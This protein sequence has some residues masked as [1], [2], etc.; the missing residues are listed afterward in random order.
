MG[1]S[2]DRNIG[3][4][5]QKLRSGLDDDPH[6]K[7]M[8]SL[9]TFCFIHNVV[10]TTT[11]DDLALEEEDMVLADLKTQRKKLNVKKH[12]VLTEMKTELL[13]LLQLAESELESQIV[14]DL[15]GLR[16]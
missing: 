6:E 7:R 16:L 2:L 10:P 8:G 15:I 3:K 14:D 13:V 1:A 12:K 11:I 5:K 9:A 4:G